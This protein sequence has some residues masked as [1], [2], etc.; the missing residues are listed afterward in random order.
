MYV[1]KLVIIWGILRH[2]SRLYLW[3]WVTIS[4]IEYCWRYESDENIDKECKMPYGWCWCWNQIIN[5]NDYP[6]AS[7]A[8]LYTYGAFHCSRERLGIRWSLRTIDRWQLIA[9]LLTRQREGYFYLKFNCNSTAK[10]CYNEWKITF[11]VDESSHPWLF[12][13]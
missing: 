3:E 11:H 9:K 1:I 2:L 8:H 12:T 5:K 4:E 6:T 13:Y 10:Y 7:E